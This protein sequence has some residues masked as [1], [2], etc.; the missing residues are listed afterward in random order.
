MPT[1]KPDLR[2]VAD[3]EELGRAGAGEIARQARQAGPQRPF[4][5]AL[6]GGQTPRG[7]YTRLAEPPYLTLVPWKFVH[8]FWGDERHVPPDHADSNYRM[9]RETLLA[10]API[11]PGNVHRVPAEDADAAAA[12]RTYEETLRVFF[13]LKEGRTPRFDLILLGLGAD[14]HI[15]SLF[16]GDE[17]LHDSARLVAA[18]RASTPG[19]ERI[20]LTS[21][22][23]ANASSI[24]VL[25]AGDAKAEAL[26][27]ALAP[28][29]R[30]D[31]CPARLLLEAR[32]RSIVIADRS[33][34][35]LVR[36]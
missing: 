21:R 6:S 11:P 10:K 13:K 36:S 23:I 33:A 26:R 19:A 20:T 14:G 5:L 24:V 9:V 32:G 18:A 4:S 2:V 17:T 30:V 15:A 12:A 8:L 3:L 22:T 25:V 34:A 27:R 31:D 29:G 16:P 28:E 1:S 35:R 7:V